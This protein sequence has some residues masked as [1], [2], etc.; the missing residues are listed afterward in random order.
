MT[1]IVLKVN[2]FAQPSSDYGDHFDHPALFY[3]FD[4]TCFK[5]LFPQD[6]YNDTIAIIPSIEDFVMRIDAHQCSQKKVIIVVGNIP[7]TSDSCIIGD[8]KFEIRVI[9]ILRAK[10]EENNASKYEAI[11][12]M[13][14]KGSSSYWKQERKELIT[15]QCLTGEDIYS[16][17][18]QSSDEC[19][20]STNVLLFM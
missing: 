17:M 9:C 12:Y 13:Q 5:R 4:I 8:I 6:K 16:E 14:K 7:P 19:T 3:K 20:I 11:R 1:K 2:E 18:N 15:T 10:T